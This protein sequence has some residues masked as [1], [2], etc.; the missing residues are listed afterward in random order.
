SIFMDCGTHFSFQLSKMGSY[1][2]TPENERAVQNHPGFHNIFINVFQNSIKL[3]FFDFS[4]L[5]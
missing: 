5:I 2:I 1:Q 4:M 3:P